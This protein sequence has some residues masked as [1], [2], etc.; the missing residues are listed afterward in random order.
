LRKE[1]E[2]AVCGRGSE[3]RAKSLARD[4]SLGCVRVLVVVEVGCPA[5]WDC[6]SEYWDW[7]ASSV[8]LSFAEALG[9][10]RLDSS[11]YELR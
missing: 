4:G 8:C 5:N 7:R 6:R 10:V 1:D 2:L 11:H 3:A 9:G